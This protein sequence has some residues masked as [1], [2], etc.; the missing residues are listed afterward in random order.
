MWKERAEAAEAEVAG[1]KDRIAQLERALNANGK[2]KKGL[3]DGPPLPNRSA[4]PVNGNVYAGSLP[5]ADIYSYVK[6]AAME[7]APQILQVLAARPELRVR[8]E[9]KILE[10]DETSIRGAIALLI[11]AGFFTEPRK[12]NAVLEELTKR[13]H[14]KFGFGTVYEGLKD[15]TRMGFLVCAG[16]EY[17]ST[18]LKVTVTK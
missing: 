14:M 4:I 2:P 12:G 16:K 8:V 10:V 5:L 18:G 15:V 13:R 11:H 17:T 1:L 6:H 7:D 9:P 3:D